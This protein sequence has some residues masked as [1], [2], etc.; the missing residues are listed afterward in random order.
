MSCHSTATIS[1]NGQRKASQ[2][3]SICSLT[4]KTDVLSPKD[5]KDTIGLD[6]F[7][8]GTDELRMERGA[9]LPEWFEEGGALFYLQTDFLYSINFRAKKETSAPPDRCKW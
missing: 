9:P 1:P 5:C 4:P 3:H 8:P 7:K 2:A 6:M